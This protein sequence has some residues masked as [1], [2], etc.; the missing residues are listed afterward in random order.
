MGGNISDARCVRFVRGPWFAG[1]AFFPCRAVARRHPACSNSGMMMR[2]LVLLLWLASGR[3]ALAYQDP[4]LVER[5]VMDFLAVQT[6]GLPGQVSFKVTPPD[7][8]NNL[9]PC[10]SLGVELTPGARLWGRGSV[11]VQC[12]VAGGWKIYVP[13]LVRVQGQYLRIA[14][15]LIL[16]QVLTD[17]DLT[18][19]TGELTALPDGI[20]TDVRQAVGR[21]A[22]RSLPAGQPLRGDMLRQAWALQ[23]GQTVKVVSTGPGFQVTAG[24]GRALNHAAEGQVAQVR[25]PNGHVVSGLARAGGVVEVS[26]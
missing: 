19:A 23:Q 26:Y 14:R 11:L 9:A 10:P 8:R 3:F 12:Q 4:L 6:Q 21:S 22:V 17:A 2:I 5:A 7:P 18:L 15:A 20:L 24:D 16:G 13:V 1:L 25:M